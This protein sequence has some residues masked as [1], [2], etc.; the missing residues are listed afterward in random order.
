MLVLFPEG[1]RSESGKLQEGKRGIGT[2]ERLGNAVVVPALITGSNK[3]LSFGARWIKRARIS[4]AFDSPIH[5]SDIN[6][7]GEHPSEN[8]IKTIMYR[9]GE[10]KKRYADNSS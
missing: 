3:A 6:T 9:I 4:I 1:R 10:L 8:I 5:L 7:G 2:I